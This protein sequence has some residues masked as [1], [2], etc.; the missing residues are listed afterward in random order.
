LYCQFEVSVF[1]PPSQAHKAKRPRPEH[2]ATNLRLPNSSIKK[3]PS[4]SIPK[5]NPT[6]KLRHSPGTRQ[7]TL[8]HLILISIQK[9]QRARKP[10]RGTTLREV[11]D[12]GRE[13][14]VIDAVVETACGEA[15]G[16]ALQAVSLLY[17][18]AVWEAYVLDAEMVFG[19]VLVGG[20]LS[21]AAEMCG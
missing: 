19:V 20:D 12:F 7:I 15:L 16:M 6:V 10:R 17:L 14:L 18:A 9:R 1:I 2:K 21:W 5:R 11:V 4:I 3:R 8:P 13:G